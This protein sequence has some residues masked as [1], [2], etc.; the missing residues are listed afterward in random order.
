[1]ENQSWN[2]YKFEIHWS[3]LE[4]VNPRSCIGGRKLFCVYSKKFCLEDNSKTAHQVGHL[5]LKPVDLED[6]YKIKN[7]INELE[8]ILTGTSI[9]HSDSVMENNPDLLQV[10]GVAN[11]DTDVTPDSS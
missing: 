6:F 2:D 10:A 4:W 8:T 3:K 5:K 9:E 7:I 11:A 1:M